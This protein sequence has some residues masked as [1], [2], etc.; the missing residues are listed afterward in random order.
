MPIVRTRE[1]DFR[2]LP[3]IGA[4]LNW[5]P[6]IGELYDWVPKVVDRLSDTPGFTEVSLA[7]ER[8]PV[9]LI[10]SRNE[11]CPAFRHTVPPVSRTRWIAASIVS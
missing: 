9:T 6:E 2:V 10:G 7:P 1:P 3:G 8:A 11:Y 4:R 5:S